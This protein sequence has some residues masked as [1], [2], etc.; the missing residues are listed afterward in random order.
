ML[1]HQPVTDLPQKM[2]ALA[3]LREQLIAIAQRFG[4]PTGRHITSMLAAADA[5]SELAKAFR[6]HFV[7]A[8]RDEGRALLE[9]AIARNEINSHTHVESMLDMLYGAVFFRLLIGHAPLDG[10]FID[11][12]IAQAMLGM[13]KRAV[14]RAIKR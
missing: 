8:R 3:Q 1:T 12:L 10:A 2:P 9:Q 4:S 7:L 11:E 14:V 13:K 6:G 5:G